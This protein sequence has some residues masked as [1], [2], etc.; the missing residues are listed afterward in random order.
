MSNIQEYE[1]LVDRVIVP[2]YFSTSLPPP[3]FSEPAAPIQVIGE[4]SAVEQVVARIRTQINSLE[5]AN[6]RIQGVDLGGFQTLLFT[7]NNGG[8]IREVLAETGCAIVVPPLPVHKVYV[9]GPTSRTPEA[10]NA[11][12]RKVEE[13]KLVALDLC[14]AFVTAPDG[15]KAHAIEVLR[16]ARKTPEVRQIEKE[17]DVELIY[18]TSDTLYDLNKPCYIFIVGKSKE[19]VDAATKRVKTT[20]GSYTPERVAHIDV[21]PLHHKYII[22]KDG[23]GAKKISAQTAVELLFP[24]DSED[25]SIAL[26]YEGDSKDSIA[27]SEA[28][29]K[30][31]AEIREIVKGQ[32]EIITRVMD[33]PKEL[34]ILEPRGLD[35]RLTVLDVDYMTRSVAT[36]VPSSTPLIQAPSPCNSVH[37]RLDLGNPLR[38]AIQALRT[39][40]S[41]V[42]HPLMSVLQRPTSTTLSTLQRIGRLQRS[43]AS[44]S[45]IRCSIL[46]I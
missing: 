21:D 15:A 44:L 28:L 29:E 23:K 5:A 36:A 26:I 16:H 20:F 32:V 22:G 42:V 39:R 18:P 46:A 19:Y 14:K 31:K 13:Y 41:C 2:D 34:A 3:D 33:I 6:Y 37:P 17:C 40:S 10:M 27:I 30:T 24:E 9:V 45:N 12:L 35:G 11:V 4:K 43:S 7:R 1:N 38:I 25:E 8:L